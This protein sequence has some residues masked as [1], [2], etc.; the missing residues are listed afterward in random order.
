MTIEKVFPSGAW[1]VSG[2][3]EG[4]GDHYFL[5]RVYYGYSKREAIS[6]WRKHIREE[7]N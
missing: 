6:L 4:E 2:V 1:K 5:N 7:N 3:I